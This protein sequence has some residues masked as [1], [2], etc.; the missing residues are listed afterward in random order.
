MSVD[1]ADCPGGLRKVQ[2]QVSIS[3]KKRRKNDALG[4]SLFTRDQSRGFSLESS[5]KRCLLIEQLLS[6]KI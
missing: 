4:R 2:K 3:R 1:I 6:P 5:S